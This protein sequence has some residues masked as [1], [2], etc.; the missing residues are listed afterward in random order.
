MATRETRKKLIKF[1]E[2]AR[3]YL[4]IAGRSEAPK[5]AAILLLIITIGTAGTLFFEHKANED[6]SHVFETVWFIIVTLTT[7]GYGDRSPVTPG[8]RLFGMLLMM[9]G[10]AM[11]GV[12][13][14][15][16]ASFLVERQMRAG[17][18][19]VGMS[20]MENH[21]L[22]CGWKK[23]LPNILEDIMKVNPGVKAE[24]IV[25]INRMDTNTIDDLKAIPKFASI[26]F[27]Y[28]DHSDE[29]TLVR[30]NIKKARSIMILADA[31]EAATPLE[32]DSRTVM[33][34]LTAESLNKRL[35]ICA[36]LLN[37]KFERHLQ[38]GNVD[39]VI[40]S[41]DYSRT[42]IAN[43]SSASGIGHVINQLINVDSNTPLIVNCYP[44]EYVGKTFKDLCDYY[45]D[46]EYM[47]IG[48]LENTGNLFQRKQ[49]AL[50]DAQK[51]P[52]I[53]KL[54]DNLKHV[55]GIKGNDPI[56]NP[57][58]DYVLNKNSMAILIG[59]QPRYE[60]AV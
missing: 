10:V 23:D 12:V 40:L 33:A 27:I 18:G 6:L 1:K 36:E 26:K 29:N 16:I 45:N 22:I 20:K 28:G 58:G 24:N 4:I 38:L 25:L 30:A 48:I 13:T 54:V 43:A 17:K 35:Y 8:G 7:V 47:L 56:I 5:M 41:Q 46:Q 53:S 49:E 15:R 50:K 14:G 2:A 21:F 19:L 44:L 39:E 52:D 11:M 51:T 59:R 55:K 32:I 34:A 9:V 60:S 37:S 3:E 57:P 31:S 42:L